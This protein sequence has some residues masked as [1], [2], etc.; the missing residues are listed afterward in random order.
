MKTLTFTLGLLVL[1]ST[2]FAGA[3]V[4]SSLEYTDGPSAK[5]DLASLGDIK[6]Y[7]KNANTDIIRLLTAASQLS[8]S[9]EIK[10]KLYSGISKIIA[11]SKDSRSVLLL[12]HSLQAG[13]TLVKLI[14]QQSIQRGIQFTPQGTVDQQVRIMK[15]SLNFAKE[16]FESDF[17]FINGVLAKNEAKTNPKFVEFGL[18][19]NTFLIK[20]SDGVLNARSNYGMIRWSLAVLANYIK[21]DKEKGIAY[22]STRYNIAKT[23]TEKDMSGQ[24][25]YPD[26]V[27]GE[28]APSDVDCIAKV[29]ALKLLSKQSIEEINAVVIKKVEPIVIPSATPRP[30]TTATPTPSPIPL[31]T[32]TPKPSPSTNNTTTSSTSPSA[33]V[34]KKYKFIHSDN[35]SSGKVYGY[36]IIYQMNGK[37]LADLVDWNYGSSPSFGYVVTTFETSVGTQYNI[38]VGSNDLHLKPTTDSKKLM[39]FNNDSNLGTL[40]LL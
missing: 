29:R 5:L 4:N 13:M 2:Q 11:D 18:K 28:A 35:T 21:N 25:V 38:K 1:T 31:P 40:Y 20:M 39:Y 36:I 33:V 37:L 30:N 23:L 34:L 14:D 12:T 3:Q 10:N 27:N 16:Y 17:A 6:E 8:D 15:Q 24:P 9:V 32:A 7:A 26:L 19:M 22:A